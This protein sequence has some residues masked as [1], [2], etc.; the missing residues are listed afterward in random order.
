MAFI[1]ISRA[2]YIH[3]LT[4]LSQKAGGKERLM[5]VLKDNAYGHGLRIMAKIAASFEIKKACVKNI[6]EALEICELFEEVLVLV[7]HPPKQSV[8]KNISIG[9]NSLEGLQNILPHT[10]VHLKIDTGMHRNGL[11]EEEFDTA[12]EIICK[13]SLR[14]RG[15][16]THFRSVDEVGS[17][18]FWQTQEYL[19]LAQCMREKILACNIPMPPFHSCNSGALLRKVGELEDD[20]ARCGIASYGYT[21]MHP[22][23]GVYDLK[24]VLSLWGE[25]LSSRML[26]KGDKIGYGGVYEVQ[27]PCVIGAY[28]V[29]YGDGFLRSDGLKI[30]TCKEGELIVGRSSMDSI[31][32]ISDKEKICIFDNAH[33]IA[34]QFNTITYEITTKLSPLI[35]REII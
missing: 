32:V 20:Y 10:A 24:P 22:S 21:H 2:N 18:Y 11:F 17:E 7:T 26:Q 4:L 25:K 6:A 16:F 1:Q 30:L 35:P 33:A 29:G 34:S 12:L 28:D 13:N 19:R 3:N 31:F 5:V 14:L 27:K 23:F 8:A 9:I 15:V